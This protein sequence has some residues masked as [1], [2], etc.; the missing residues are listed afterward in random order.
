MAD[1]TQGSIEIDADAAA[2]MEEILDY[3]SYPEW[4]S[5]M[6]KV[7]VLSRDKQ[8]R[9]KQVHFEVAQGPL[10]ADYT[11]EYTYEPN[12]AGVSW[13]FVEGNNIRDMTG[14]YSLEP[15]GK[16]RTKVTYRMKVDTP[17]PMLGFMKRQIEK[18]IIDVALKGLKKR[19]ESKR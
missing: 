8:K 12:N 17:I 16:G 4:T 15:A 2:V 14:A 7:K 9:G 19:V 11:L 10:K 13:T 5:E 6:K 18:K 1:Q 3:D